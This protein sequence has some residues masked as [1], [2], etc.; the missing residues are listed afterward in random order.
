MV[1]Q[2]V[3]KYILASISVALDHLHRKKII[4][5]N[6]NPTNV[7]IRN[8]GYLVLTDFSC[9]KDL[10]ENG[11]TNSVVGVPYYM[12]PEVIQQK[13]Y[14]YSADIWSIGVLLYELMS[15]SLPFG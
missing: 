5:R 6:L 13:E 8:S 9:A 10:G 15:G 2:S 7:M 1:P 3:I 4:Y 12:A 11:R 14:T